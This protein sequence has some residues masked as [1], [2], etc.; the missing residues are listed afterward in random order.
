MKIRSRCVIVVLHISILLLLVY[1]RMLLKSIN[2]LRGP[3][4]GGTAV[5]GRRR[6]TAGAAAGHC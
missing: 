3:E 6:K 2:G 4:G 1:S 5:Y